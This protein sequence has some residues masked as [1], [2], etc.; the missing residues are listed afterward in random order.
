MPNGGSDCC[1][2]CWFNRRNQ[3]RHGYPKD[4]T[5]QEPYCDIRD[6][7]IGNPFYTYCANHPHRRPE[8]DPIPIGPTI[9]YVGGE[10][11]VT[12]IRSPDTEPIRKHLLELLVNFADILP[13]D[14]YPAGPSLGEVVIRQVGEFQDRRAIESLELIAE[15]NPEPWAKEA[16]IALARIR[17]GFAYEDVWD[18]S[19]SRRSTKPR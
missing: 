16:R 14:S 2:T 19:I 1:G 11:R 13:E 5:D 15:H 18:S 9:R 4:Q 3:G 17:G 6:V 10:V 12:W 8:R 7:V